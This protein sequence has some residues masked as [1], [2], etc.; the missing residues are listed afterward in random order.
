MLY[1]LMEY[2]KSYI[3]TLNYYSPVEVSLVINEGKIKFAMF[4]SVR[5]I[6]Q[7]QNG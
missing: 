3:R 1:M 6:G 7:Q 5:R 4:K 2:N